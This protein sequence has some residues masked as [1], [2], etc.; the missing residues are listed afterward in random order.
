MV[1]A[2]GG[3]LHGLHIALAQ[4]EDLFALEL[5][6]EAGLRQEEHPIAALG[7]DFDP[8]FHEAVIAVAGISSPPLEVRSPFSG[9][10]TT[11]RSPVSRSCP[12]GVR[13]ARWRFGFDAVFFA[14]VFVVRF[15]V[16]FW[17]RFGAGRSA[18]SVMTEVYERVPCDA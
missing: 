11:S 15:C 14:V 3:G 1:A 6:L 7:Q 2:V 9:V 10:R 5:D 13:S 16:V 18:A 4:Q 17:A 12:S 8:N